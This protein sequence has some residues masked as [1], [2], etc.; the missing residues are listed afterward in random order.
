MSNEHNKKQVKTALQDCL[1]AKHKA[2]KVLSNC[3]IDWYEIPGTTVEIIH[4]KWRDNHVY[5]EYRNMS[6][7]HEHRI[8]YS[9]LQGDQNDAIFQRNAELGMLI[10]N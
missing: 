2:T 4:T 10:P 6:D 3:N 7:P 8:I 5:I 1:R 9:D